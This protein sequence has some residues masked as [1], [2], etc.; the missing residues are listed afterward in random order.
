[1]AAV[2]DPTPFF[3]DNV[4]LSVASCSS[5]A[6]A[7]SVGAAGVSVTGA[8]PP[9]PP[10]VGCVGTAD[11]LPHAT[12]EATTMQSTHSKRKLTINLL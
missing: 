2:V 11:L 5:A 12:P 10:P 7:S 1:L 9:E 6:G 3:T 4:G 8:G